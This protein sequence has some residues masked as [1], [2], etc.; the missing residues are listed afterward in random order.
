MARLDDLPPEILT[1]IARHVGSHALRSNDAELQL[2]SRA[3]YYVAK[4]VVAEE[5]TLSQKLFLKF[6]FQEKRFHHHTKSLAIKL[7]GFP[8]KPWLRGVW[9]VD[10]PYW[11]DLIDLIDRGVEDWDTRPADDHYYETRRALDVVSQKWRIHI[12][13]SMRAF[14]SS[15]PDFAN[16]KELRFGVLDEG[17]SWGPFWPP[18]NYVMQFHVR[19]LVRG[20]P[21]ALVRLE[22]DLSGL[23]L[24]QAPSTC[25]SLCEP[26][27]HSLSKLECLRYFYL[28]SRYLCQSFLDPAELPKELKLESM[29]INL[30]LVENGRASRVSGSPCYSTHVCGQSGATCDYAAVAE[31]I[32]AAT[33]KMPRLKSAKVLGR[34]AV[35]S[36]LQGKDALNAWHYSVSGF[37]VGRFLDASC[38]TND[39]ALDKW[40]TNKGLESRSS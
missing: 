23:Q 36:D 1:L 18:G 7:Q 28:R 34:E 19:K 38:E 14:I 39:A 16:L 22:L 11:I 30:S 13:Q 31:W 9:A 6:P 15:L 29:T 24:E 3:W 10:R 26:V 12:Y 40:I 33:S 8:F 37:E 25:Q 17:A 32:L 35:S 21:M 20:L 5:V 2:I 27:C 4:I